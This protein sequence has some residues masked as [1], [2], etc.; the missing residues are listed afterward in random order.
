MFFKGTRYTS[1]SW[2]GQNC[3]ILT[4]VDLIAK[5]ASTGVHYKIKRQ[6][7]RSL[8]IFYQSTNSRLFS[9]SHCCVLLLIYVTYSVEQDGKRQIADAS[10][11]SIE[12]N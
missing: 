5:W 4:Q 3:K 1:C 9:S 12:P 11:L 10:S 8:I 7:F 6:L 2:E